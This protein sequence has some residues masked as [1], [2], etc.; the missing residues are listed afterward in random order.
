MT[1]YIESSKHKILSR[2]EEVVLGRAVLEGIEASTTLSEVKDLTA[3]QKRKLRASV[4]EGARAKEIFIEHNLRLAMDTAARYSRSQS[5][6][7][8]EDLI[9]EATIGLMRAVDKFDPDK[10]F[11]F[12][13]YATW[14]CRQACQR[15]IAN[16]GRTIRL[17]MHVEAD[18]RKLAAVIEEFE[19]SRHGFSRKD[20]ADFLDWD[21]EK[22]ENIWSHMENTRL[23]SLDNLVSEGSAME[24]VDTIQDP[25]AVDVEQAGSE[26]SFSKSIMDALSIL[27]EREL[28]V[29]I[30]HHGLDGFGT[31]LTLQEIGDRMGLTRER[32]R[33]LESKAIARL[34]H[35]ASGV[36]WA[37]SFDNI[38]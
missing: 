2:E 35:P 5:R 31:P 16:H 27:P 37:F 29:L 34:R 17:P 11:K 18:V 19:S 26:K 9:Q 6:M 12:S 4:K 21:I 23:E 20:I 1:G 22:L 7:E 36:A 13:T 8:Y 15:A 14:W 33:Q 3:V 24:Y 32:V 10:G 30:M 38:E 25:N 28:K